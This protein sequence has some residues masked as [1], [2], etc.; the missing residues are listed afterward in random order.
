MG[1][2]SLCDYD[3]QKVGKALK[4]YE[5]AVKTYKMAKAG[6]SLFHGEGEKRIYIKETFPC[7]ADFDMCGRCADFKG[8]DPELAYADYISGKREY[9]EV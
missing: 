1:K 7:I 9:M 6:G 4:V 5:G 3:P 2:L 8:K